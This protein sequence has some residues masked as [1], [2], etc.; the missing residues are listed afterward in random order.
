MARPAANAKSDRNA[1][2]RAE[3]QILEVRIEKLSKK[4][5][6]LSVGAAATFSALI[7]SFPAVGQKGPE[8]LLPSDFQQPPAPPSPPAATPPASTPSGT[9]NPSGA[10]NS[11][12]ASGEKK[13]SSKKS[14]AAGSTSS[15][16][17]SVSTSVDTA[18]A[19]ETD[20]GEPQEYVL[21][22][23]VPPSARRSL[24]QVGVF[25]AAK[26][27]FPE[28]AFGS[29]DGAFL[30]QA[31]RATQG[32]LASRWGTIIGRR[33]LAGRSNTPVG[34]EGADWVAERAWL[35]LRMGDADGARQ[36]IQQVD[37]GSYS[38]RLFEVAMPVY[39]A[40]ADL[41]GICPIVEGGSREQADGT[42]QLSRAIC[43]SLA[44]EQ[45]QA[46]SLLNQARKKKSLVGIDYLLAEKAV[47]AGMNGRR[48][49]KIEWSKVKGFNAWR[50]GLAQATG[51]EPPANLYSQ[52]GRHV[53]A[54]RAQLPALP[55]GSRLA[56][57][58]TAAAL[59][60]ISN[61]AIVDLYSQALDAEDSSE[62]SKERA[63]KLQ[64]TYTAKDDSS[65]I[66]ALNAI[67]QSADG[68]LAKT[69]A[70]VL[71]ARAASLVSPGTGSA[72]DADNIVASLMSAGLDNQAAAWGSHVASGSPAW[73]QLVTGAP[74]LGKAIAYGGLD[75]FYDNDQSDNAH[76]SALLMASLAGLDRL[77][78]GA[79][80][81][82]A[83]KLEIDL[84]KSSEW[85]NAID[86]AATRGEAGT[87]MLLT[88][89]AL[90]GTSWKQIPSEHVFHIVSGLFNVGMEAEAR[91]I[92]AEAV[93]NG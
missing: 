4:N 76:R 39:L 41:S 72:A 71:T 58:D 24:K 9:E 23:D 28:T 5:I 62:E 53:D 33:L 20:T 73:A 14:S 17:G 93:V 67:W 65:R 60:V 27:A 34:V 26:G 88:M 44:G 63:E 40:N 51:L 21:R 70:Y 77:E 43:A 78:D 79:E 54:W 36:L 66:T 89:A 55:A 56:S 48:T 90:Q 87:V 1:G 31:I 10:T 35:L 61:A 50:F 85:A 19:G 81:D 75:D 52:A 30:T 82:F 91:M 15:A 16:N 45:G 68:D 6:I 80:K 83:D 47:G 69:G 57:A 29:T 2:N 3:T 11:P 64:A 18:K 74:E 92:A 13:H 86:A 59:G 84:H 8:S 49:V 42:W 32:P 22:F 25:S 12:D 46:S 7:Y 37:V 38:K